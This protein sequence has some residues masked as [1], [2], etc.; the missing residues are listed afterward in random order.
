MTASLRNGMSF[1]ES[2][3]VS[4]AS[5]SCRFHDLFKQHLSSRWLLHACRFAAVDQACTP[6]RP[7]T[8]APASCAACSARR[9]TA[10]GPGTMA[11]PCS[12]CRAWSSPSTQPACWTACSGGARV[13]WGGEG[14]YRQTRQACC[15]YQFCTGCGCL[16]KSAQS[17]ARCCKPPPPRTHPTPPHPHHHPTP[18]Q[19]PAQG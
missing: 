15:T 10:T 19:P 11:A 5:R 12:S 4:A 6:N 14:C 2:L 18:R 8:A 9:T 17:A 7:P 16:Q 1:Y 3:Q 13:G